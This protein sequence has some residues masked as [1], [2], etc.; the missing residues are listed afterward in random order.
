MKTIEEYLQLP[1][2]YQIIKEKDESF[3]IS[4]KELEGCMSSGDTLDE[5][6][7]MV[8]EA[9]GLWIKVCLEQ[10]LRIPVPEALEEFGYSGKFVLRVGKSLHK[11]LAEA[12][13]KEGLSLN[14]FVSNL[15]SRR[16]G[17]IAELRNVVKQQNEQLGAD[18]GKEY[19]H[20]E[21]VEDWS[22]PTCIGNSI[23]L[24]NPYI[25]TSAQSRKPR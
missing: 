23:I 22:I 19:Y 18:Y 8:H 2:T 7:R 3:F 14:T 20:K 13:D 16:C 12:A 6:F 9:M 21:K 5:A 25:N 15:L 1:Y 10:G 4:V 11:E 17:V 24:P